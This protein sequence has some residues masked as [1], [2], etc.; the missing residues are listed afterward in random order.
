MLISKDNVA[1]SDC[2]LF[3]HTRLVPVI[4]TVIKHTY[5]IKGTPWWRSS[6]V[7]PFYSTLFFLPMILYTATFSSLLFYLLPSVQH[8]TR[9]QTICKRCSFECDM[10]KYSTRS[11]NKVWA[12]RRTPYSLNMCCVFTYH[13]KNEQRLYFLTRSSYTWHNCPTTVRYG[14]IPIYVS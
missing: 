2:I 6:R 1:F 13:T 9:H 8:S 3:V 7:R 10:G 11:T 4:A 5:L 12:S 14:L